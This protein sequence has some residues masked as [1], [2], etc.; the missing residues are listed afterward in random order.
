MPTFG[1]PWVSSAAR[2]RRRQPSRSRGSVARAASPDPPIGSRRGGTRCHGEPFIARDRSTCRGAE[3]MSFFAGGRGGVGERTVPRRA[4]TMHHTFRL[5]GRWLHRD[6]GGR[7]VVT[8]DVINEE[9]RGWDGSGEWR[10]RTACGQ[11]ATGAGAGT[12]T[13]G[14]S[15]IGGPEH[16]LMPVRA[17]PRGA[18]D[19]PVGTCRRPIGWRLLPPPTLY[20]S[21]TSSLKQKFGHEP[22]LT[23][24]LVHNVCLITVLR[25]KALQS[26]VLLNEAFATG[27]GK[28]DGERLC[29]LSRV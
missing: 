5:A 22:G 18:Y 12:A 27:Q 9:G 10:W 23:I 26:H 14:P 24:S 7:T 21:Y 15:T 16:E 20:S 2:I 11:R 8:M 29:Q 17:P 13:G 19:R 3:T 6:I 28:V 4:G 25:C 1:R